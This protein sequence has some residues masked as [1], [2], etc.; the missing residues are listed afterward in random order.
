MIKSCPKLKNLIFPLSILLGF[1]IT[2]SASPF[3]SNVKTISATNYA[4]D[5]A[6]AELPAAIRLYDALQ[7]SGAGLSK[8]AFVYALEG[9]RHLFSTGQIANEV[10]S[11][12]DFTLPSS[13]KRLFV[14]DMGAKKLLFNTYVAHGKNSGRESATFF[15]NEP[16]SFQSS[17]GFYVTGN[18]YKGQHGYSLRLEGLEEG[19]NDNAM[20]R[21]IVVHAAP[22]VNERLALGRGYIG[23]S[24]GCPAIPA[25]MYRP[26]IRKIRNGSCFFM[27]SHDGEY[28]SNSR[29]II[30]PFVRW[31]ITS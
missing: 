25:N 28:L 19:I 16:N 14:I 30:M 7:L 29:L 27:Y 17:L 11:I 3:S 13:K 31:P 15:S 24:E 10:L 2:T 26:I 4:E 8:E 1:L 20:S 5:A 18:T 9:Y 12:V 22:Y 23:R 21:G 6:H